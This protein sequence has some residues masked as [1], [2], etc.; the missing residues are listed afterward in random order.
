LRDCLRDSWDSFRN[1][2]FAHFFAVQR[3]QLPEFDVVRNED[4]RAWEIEATN[5]SPVARR[6][7]E[8]RFIFTKRL[9]PQKLI[10]AIELKKIVFEQADLDQSTSTF[11]KVLN[12]VEMPAN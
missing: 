3:F 1:N 4:A 5:P 8:A 7:T 10:G 6:V 11:R 9:R 2:R 12:G